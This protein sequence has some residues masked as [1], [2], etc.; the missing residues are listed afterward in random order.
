MIGG[1]DIVFE[2]TIKPHATDYLIR[3]LRVHWTN[4]IVKYADKIESFPLQ[5]LR[6]PVL[7]DIDIIVYRDSDSFQ[8]WTDYG[9][10][11]EN[12]SAMIQVV[13]TSNSVTFVVDKLS[14]ELA[15]LANDLI[16]SLSRNHIVL[17]AA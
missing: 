1:E 17:S 16:K 4:A 9:C 6:L 5:E 12:Q 14:S 7:G 10:T 8:S 2:G 3:G 15:D 11:D 13:V